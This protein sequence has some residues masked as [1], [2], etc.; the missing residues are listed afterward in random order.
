MNIIIYILFAISFIILLVGY[1]IYIFYPDS[2]RHN[3][4]REYF[5]ANSNLT[6]Q[7]PMNFNYLT[8]RNYA[9]NILAT[10]YLDDD[11]KINGQRVVSH[12]YM[13]SYG[14]NNNYGY[15]WG[16]PSKSNTIYKINGVRL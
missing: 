5:I 11:K 3:N 6:N 9:R 15:Y 16:N 1:A 10:Y 2:R 14:N 7:V 8:N 13:Y 12:P 4:S